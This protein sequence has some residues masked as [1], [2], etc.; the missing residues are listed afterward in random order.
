MPRKT[1]TRIGLLLVALTVGGMLYL[2]SVTLE[3]APLFGDV[4]SNIAS[5]AT[6]VG[7]PP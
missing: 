1:L 7:Y 6:N 3:V 4:A 5:D 2:L